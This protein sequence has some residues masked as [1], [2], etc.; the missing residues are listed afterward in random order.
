MSPR[1]LRCASA[2]AD[3]LTRRGGA[4]RSATRSGDADAE[5]ANCD[6]ARPQRNHSSARGLHSA[7]GRNDRWIARAAAERIGGGLTRLGTAAAPS[8]RSSV[9]GRVCCIVDC[10]CVL[11][12]DCCSA[13]SGISAV[14]CCAARCSDRVFLSTNTL[15]VLFLFCVARPRARR[16]AAEAATRCRELNIA[17]EEEGRRGRGGRRT[18]MAERAIANRIGGKGRSMGKETGHVRMI[19]Q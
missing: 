8:I 17:R 4:R 7:F 2:R 14:L 16:G 15:A 1:C 9:C 5:A 10:E 11:L 18:K 12:V 19:S 13:L 6:P 3:S